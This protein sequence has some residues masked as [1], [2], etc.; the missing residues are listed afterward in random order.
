[1]Q[2]CQDVFTLHLKG[3]M[4]K[5]DAFLCLFDRCCGGFYLLLQNVIVVALFW[6]TFF[7][8]TPIYDCVILYLGG[9]FLKELL[10]N[11]DN[12]GRVS[13]S[14]YSGFIVGEHNAG[15]IAVCFSNSDI[16]ECDYFR[17][18]FDRCQQRC[19]FLNC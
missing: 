16:P 6:A 19:N 9:F 4:G 1:M 12:H 10:L 14:N 8:K 17:M 5:R 7:E 11:V 15:R 18:Y 13:P 2:F 3:K